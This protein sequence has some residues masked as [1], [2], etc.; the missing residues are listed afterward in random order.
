[1]PHVEALSMI[2]LVF[3][4]RNGKVRLDQAAR[5]DWDSSSLVF[6]LWASSGA[7][8]GD[9]FSKRVPDHLPDMGLRVTWGGL[10]ISR[11]PRVPVGGLL[12]LF[13]GLFWRSDF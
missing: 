1:M 10:D 2:F 7:F 13:P 11:R 3:L 12:A 8:C 5:S 4:V 9:A 6:V